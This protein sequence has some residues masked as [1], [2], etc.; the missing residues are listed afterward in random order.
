[1]PKFT[2]NPFTN[3]LDAYVNDFGTEGIYLI[4]SNGEKWQLTVDTA[5]ALITTLI[6][7]LTFDFMDGTDFAFM[8]DVTFDFMDA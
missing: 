1:M 3:N 6:E 4:D 8:D 7:T 2:F 5:G